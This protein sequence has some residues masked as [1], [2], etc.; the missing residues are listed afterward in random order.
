MTKY[1]KTMK[2]SFLDKIAIRA[3][4]STFGKIIKEESL[5]SSCIAYV[6]YT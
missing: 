3:E 6:K 2:L 4:E 1:M 5:T